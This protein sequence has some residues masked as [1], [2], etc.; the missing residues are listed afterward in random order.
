MVWLE[1]GCVPT[2][3]AALEPPPWRQRLTCHSADRHYRGVEYC[4]AEDGQVHV[5]VVDLYSSGV[6]LEYIIAQGRDR[7]AQFGECRDVNVPRYGPVRGG[8]ADAD[9]PAYYPVLALAD[10]ARRYPG[11]AAIVNS[12]YGA[13]TQ[14]RPG[15]FRGHGP[16]G[17]AVVRGDRLDG[18]ANG[19]G[20]NNAV[21]RPWL[22]VSRDAPLRAELGQWTGDDGGKP[23]W[24]YTGAGG[25][26]W[27]IR[28]GMIQQ[29]DIRT[30]KN[31]PGSCYD[32]AAQ[33]AAG[34]SQDR[35]WLFLVVDV[36]KG[37]LLD[38]AQWMRDRLAA[39]DAIKF[40][41]GG[42]SQLWYGGQVV[43]AGDGRKLSQFLAVI[44]EP[45]AGIQDTV[46][47]AGLSVQPTSPLFFDII[48]PGETAHLK[49]EVRNTG[50]TTWQPG[51]GIALRRVRQDVVSPMVE[52]YPLPHAVAPG[53]TA[54]WEIALNV[55]GDRFIPL[56]SQMHQG[57]RPFGPQ[58]GAL[59]IILPEQ[60]KTQEETIR[61]LIERQLR[62]C[63]QHAGQEVERQLEELQKRLLELIQRE[64][65]RQARNLIDQFC[66]ASALLPIGA[67]ALWWMR[68]RRK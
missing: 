5:I 6:R 59:V 57:D 1:N 39:W 9:Q 25:G 27:L 29:E 65:E 10:A 18:P 60:L 31:T 28:N 30:C 33:T 45:G 56:R 49:I 22:A 52:S 35:R 53:E 63:Q 34:L 17:L 23:D 40:D 20:D 50:A 11:T 36:R 43:E 13:G 3:Y 51:Q 19:D 26:P 16:E 21:R 61:Q 55:G 14:G 58:I 54:S 68:Q 42:S 7:H 2:I 66:G 37:K 15:E 62:A 38:L 48:L 4:T 41:G 32:G 12:D 24:I 8:C 46:A 64:V 44:A 67:V 47:V